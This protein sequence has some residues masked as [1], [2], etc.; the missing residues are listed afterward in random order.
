MLTAVLRWVL[1]AV[2]VVED[3][4]VRDSSS[5]LEWLEASSKERPSVSD[6]ESESL[7]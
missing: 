6:P 3:R 7:R 1:V 4:F 2:P 5:S